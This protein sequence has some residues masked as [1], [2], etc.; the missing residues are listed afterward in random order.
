VN[1]Q[2]ADVGFFV[3]CC[4]VGRQIDMIRS[5][6][7]KKEKENENYFS[8]WNTRKCWNHENHA[9]CSFVLQT[10]KKEERNKTTKVIECNGG[11]LLLIL[12]II[13][14]V[15]E[16]KWI[17][18]IK[19]QKDDENDDI[20][21]TLHAYIIVINSLTTPSS[22]FLS[23]DILCFFHFWVV[24]SI[25]FYDDHAFMKYIHSP[26]HWNFKWKRRTYDIINMLRF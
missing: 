3:L 12:I 15:N 8:A 14:M 26:W 11:D 2:S 5:K 25:T 18:E 4:W 6:R 21:P 23:F 24:V 17:K 1:W 16:M 20:T 7:Q 9:N 22:Q 19:S 13:E 10:N